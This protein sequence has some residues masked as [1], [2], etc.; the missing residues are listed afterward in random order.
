MAKLSEISSNPVQYC[1]G[2]L[3]FW[4]RHSF[5]L[6]GFFDTDR[7]N[8]L[9]TPIAYESLITANF[10][11]W[12]RQQNIQYWVPEWSRM[13]GFSCIIVVWDLGLSILLCN[14]L[15]ETVET[16]GKTRL[17]SSTTSDN[18]LSSFPSDRCCYSCV[19]FAHH[20]QK[21][22]IFYSRPFWEQAES[23]D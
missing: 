3:C 4:F 11:I 23:S 9:E 19:K 13:P 20:L 22:H 21:S 18:L 15:L 2:P 12:Y 10:T 7:I 16:S 17:A 8:Y 1:I 14:T 5:L 6:D